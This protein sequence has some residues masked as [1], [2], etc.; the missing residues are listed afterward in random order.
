MLLKS[1]LQLQLML[2]LLLSFL[3]LLQRLLLLLQVL[4]LQ[5]APAASAV[6]DATFTGL[7]SVLCGRPSHGART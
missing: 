1:Q 3:V 2:L 5:K 6:E 7:S 4:L